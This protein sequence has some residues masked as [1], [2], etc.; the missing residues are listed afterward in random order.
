MIWYTPLSVLLIRPASTK[1][2]NGLPSIGPG[3]AAAQMY[4]RRA[5][6]PSA[7]ALSIATCRFVISFSSWPRVVA[8]VAPA[9]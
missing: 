8:V 2:V 9:A 3:C 7:S 4:F 6:L 1:F 5:G